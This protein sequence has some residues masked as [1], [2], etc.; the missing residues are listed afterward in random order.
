MIAPCSED[1]ENLVAPP[2]TVQF[3]IINEFEQHFSASTIVTCY[4]RRT[5]RQVST[6]VHARDARLRDGPPRRAGGP[7]AGA[8]DAGRSL[9][10]R[11]PVRLRPPATSRRCAAAARR[12]SAFP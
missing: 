4:A 9:P 1:L 5:L 11:R 7:D 2:T 3:E 8:G 6:V 12:R 10:E